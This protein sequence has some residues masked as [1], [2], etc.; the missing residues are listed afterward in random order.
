MKLDV[1]INCGLCEAA[2]KTAITLPD[3]WAHRY[4]GIDD[5]TKGFCPKHAAV[6]EFAE[7]QCAG[8]VG[9]WTDC[10]LWRDFAYNH[11]RNLTE[12]DFAKLEQGVC[13]RRTNGSLMV[14][15]GPKGAVIKDIYLSEVAPSEA[16][17]VLAQAIREC[18]ARYPVRP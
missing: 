16:G 13:P 8:C 2:H 6:A 1:T 3:G 17:K 9:G 10:D 7:A 12:A 4:D 14:E 11:R 18:W 15:C 5:E